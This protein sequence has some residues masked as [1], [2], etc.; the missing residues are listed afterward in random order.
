M[1]DILKSKF[2]NEA[3][4]Q[5]LLATGN[6]YLL[7]HNEFLGR[8]KFWSDNKDG[9]GYNALGYMLMILR[10]DLGGKN[11]NDVTLETLEIWSKNEIKDKKKNCDKQNE[12]NS[13]TQAIGTT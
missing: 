11:L 12:I 2:Q 7:E 9:T 1:Y 13:Y 3:L 6:A 5:K 8:D 4:K 10:A